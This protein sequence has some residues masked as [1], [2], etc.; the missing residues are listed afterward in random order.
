MGKRKQYEEPQVEV[1]LLSEDDVVSTSDFNVDVDQ[2]N[3][4]AD[5]TEPED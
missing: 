2:W 3:L 1:I 5:Q 4:D